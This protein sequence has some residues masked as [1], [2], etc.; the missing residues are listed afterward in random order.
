MLD[1]SGAL[2]PSGTV[3]VEARVWVRT[4]LAKAGVTSSAARRR[5]DQAG[6]F[7]KWRTVG[8]VVID[9]R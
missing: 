7:I 5:W 6:I 8:L 1:H 4:G 9:R 3:S 2:R